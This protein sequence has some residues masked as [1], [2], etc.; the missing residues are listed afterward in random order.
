MEQDIQCNV[1]M[2]MDIGTIEN[3]ISIDTQQSV[4]DTE[5]VQSGLYYGGIA[6]FQ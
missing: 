2:Q 6:S 3:D 4:Y 1:G 5:G